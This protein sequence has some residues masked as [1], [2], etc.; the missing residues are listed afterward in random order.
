MTILFVGNT[1]GDVGGMAEEGTGGVASGTAGKERDTAFSPQYLRVNPGNDT[2]APFV[3]DHGVSTGDEY[4]LHFSYATGNDSASVNADG[5]VLFV[6]DAQ[7]RTVA[8]LDVQDGQLRAAAYG[9]TTVFG[10]GFSHATYSAFVFDIRVIVGANIVCEVY[11]GGTLVSTATAANTGAKGKPKRVLFINNDTAAASNTTTHRYFTE[12]ICTEDEPTIGWRLAT[13]PPV[14]AG[15]HTALDGTVAGLLA[16]GDGLGLSSDTPGEKGSWT[17]GAYGGPSSPAG[18]IRAVI[19]KT[20]SSKGPV[21]APQKVRPFL[22][23]GSTDY[24][25][26]ADV[27]PIPG[28]GEM[29]I[30][31]VNPATGLPWTTSELSGIQQGIEI[32]A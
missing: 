20:H 29:G 6:Q 14:A 25:A 4:W 28:R 18:G 27:T 12:I 15:F 31:D 19:A 7:Q 26:A 30:F 23:I 22:R 24:P 3:A 13:L 8:A 21:S 16:P 5:E 2:S 32:K 11:L 1:R 17:I 10:T 9:D